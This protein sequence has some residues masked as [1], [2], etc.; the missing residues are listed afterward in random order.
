[1]N[2]NNHQRNDMKQ[3]TLRI[4]LLLVGLCLC[5]NFTWAQNNAKDSIS[6][7]WKGK[8]TS[9]Q[10]I[11]DKYHNLKQKLTGSD[12]ILNDCNMIWYSGRYVEMG[13][14]S[15]QDI[16]LFLANLPTIDVDNATAISFMKA[17]RASDFVNR[18]YMFKNLKKG[19]SL[20]ASRDALDFTTEFPLRAPNQNDYDKLTDVFSGHNQVLQ[21]SYLKIFDFIFL[22]N[23]CTEGMAKV[24]P[25]VMK[26]AADS[27]LKQKAMELY[28]KYEPIQTGKPAPQSVLKD[29]EGKTYTFNKYKGKV[30]VIDVW[31]TWCSSCLKKMPKFIELKNS[32]ADRKDI[33]FLTISTDRSKA[34]ATWAKDIEKYG[35]SVMPNLIAD[36]ENGS[37]FETDYC[38]I[39]LPRYII[40]DR[41]G[42]IANAFA[43]GPDSEIIK[44]QIQQ[45]LTAK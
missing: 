38:V 22:N 17:C 3:A 16:D 21:E 14:R 31:A 39:G 45:A 18:Y 28:A 27:K 19:D 10:E 29:A 24:K 4:A 9:A 2:K 40:I 44:Q 25:L 6:L 33:I 12:A 7:I 34:R 1:M 26:N 37:S 30:I 42:R 20:D 15:K 5:A 8:Y 41:K 11:V 36:V 43:A 23:G 32:F 13:G 35:M